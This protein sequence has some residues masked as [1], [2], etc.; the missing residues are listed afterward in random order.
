[1]PLEVVTTPLPLTLSINGGS[2]TVKSALFTF[3][4]APR[5]VAGGAIADSGA[6]AV[7][8]LLEWVAAGARGAP[9]AAVGHRIVHGGPTHRE[10]VR[11]TTAILDDLANLIPF[12]PNHLPDEIALIESIGALHPA[13]PQV[14]CFDTAFHAD[15]RR[16]RGVCRFRS[17]YDAAGFAATA[18]MALSYAFLAR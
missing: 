17:R 3:E 1:M 4:S 16:W 13:T 5:L 6:D 10:P 15:L 18:S 14:A 8:H 12:A 9:L 11:I 7:P 2:S